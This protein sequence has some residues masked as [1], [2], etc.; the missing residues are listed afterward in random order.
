MEEYTE[1]LRQLN[2]NVK[3][4]NQNQ[5]KMFNKM[6][7]MQKALAGISDESKNQK[8]ELQHLRQE[9]VLGAN[10]KDEGRSRQTNTTSTCQ[11]NHHQRY[12]FC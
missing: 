4:L 8:A 6:E 11:R 10:E 7:E 3:T 1:Q 12:S 9:N 5:D 2:G